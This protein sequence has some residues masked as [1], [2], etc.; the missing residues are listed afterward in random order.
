M[1]DSSIESQLRAFLV[2]N[3]GYRGATPDLGR[4]VPLLD[5]G[6]LDSTGVLEIVAWLES[7]LGV[8]VADDEMVPDH[9]GSIAL[10]TSYVERKKKS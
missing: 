2:D 5:E 1:S 6:I 3:F 9:F 10:L 4:D 7:A 8:T